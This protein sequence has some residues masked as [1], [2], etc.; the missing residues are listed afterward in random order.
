MD[1]KIGDKVE[2]KKAHPCGATI[3]EVVRIGA[4]IKIKCTGCGHEI[5][6][7]RVKVEKCIKKIINSEN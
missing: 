1:L 6:N 7:P 4:D 3:W 2:M 5:M